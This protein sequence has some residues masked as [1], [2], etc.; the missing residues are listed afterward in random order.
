MKIISRKAHGYLDYL[1]GILLIASPWLFN[2]YAGGAESWL[3]I[4]LGA[5]TILYSLFTN[6]ELGMIKLMDMRTHLVMDFAAGA[7]LALSP[8]IF[9]FADMVFVPHLVIGLGE[10]LVAIMTNPKPVSQE[11]LLH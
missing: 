10:I 5:G 3:P 1:V 6:Y 4:I 11:D 9:G 8:W 7:F 2:F